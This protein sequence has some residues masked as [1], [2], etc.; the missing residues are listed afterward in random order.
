[1]KN[2]TKIL[3][4]FAALIFF[5]GIF[6][7][8][9]AD[10]EKNLK[11]TP[12][13]P[14]GILDKEPKPDVYWFSVSIRIDYKRQDIEILGCDTQVVKGSLKSFLKTAKKGIAHRQFV[15]GPFLSED[16]ANY[17]KSYYKKSRNEIKEHPQ[18]A[19]PKMMHWF[20]CALTE[21]HSGAYKF[22]R[23]P[24]AVSSG[25]DYEF[26]KDLFEGIQYQRFTVGLFWDYTESEEAKAIYRLLE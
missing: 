11:T 19:A 5:G 15:V 22:M 14:E 9:A 10:P 17:A 24:A 7:A 4:L 8:S 16:E 13:S 26:V 18:S 23:C 25:S 2:I 20:Q 12:Q 6:K 1:M 3:L 21:K